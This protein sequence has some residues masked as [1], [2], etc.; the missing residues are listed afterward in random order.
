MSRKGKQWKLLI[1]DVAP[2]VGC[3]IPRLCAANG[4]LCHQS[5]TDQVRGKQQILLLL[6]SVYSVFV[7]GEY[8]ISPGKRRSGKGTQGRLLVVMG[9]TLGWRGLCNAPLQ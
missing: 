5:Y 7:L 8:P 2:A 3:L 1:L 4:A 9:V 6:G